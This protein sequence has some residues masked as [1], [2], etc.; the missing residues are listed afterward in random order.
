MNYGFEIAIY[1]CLWSTQ[2]EDFQSC[3]VGKSFIIDQ[4]AAV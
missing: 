2:T 1:S 3:N 4:Q